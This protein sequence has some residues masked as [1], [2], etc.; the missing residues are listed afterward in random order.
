AGGIHVVAEQDPVGAGQVDVA[1][2]QPPTR[3]ER[4][5][6]GRQAE[7][8]GP[9][10]DL[11]GRQRQRTA[12]GH[13]HVRTTGRAHDGQR[14]VVR[15]ADH[16]GSTGKRDLAGEVVAHVV[17]CD[18]TALRIDRRGTAHPQRARLAHAPAVAGHGQGTGHRTLAQ[19]QRAMLV[20]ESV[21]TS[22]AS[23]VSALA[24]TM[25]AAPPANDTVP[26]KSLPAFART[27]LPLPA[28]NRASPP[29]RNAPD[30]LMSPALA[31][32][33]RS[34][35]TSTREALKLPAS[36]SSAVSA[37]AAPTAP[38]K[39]TAPAACTESRCAPSTVPPKVTS[40]PESRATSAP[41][42]SAPWYSWSPLVLTSFARSMVAARTYRWFASI[43]PR[44]SVLA[45]AISTAPPR[46]STV[47]TKSLPAWLRMMLPLPASNRAS[48][49]TRNAPDWVIA[50]LERTSAAPATTPCPR[51]SAPPLA[52]TRRSAA[53]SPRPSTFASAI[54]TE[55]PRRPTVPTKSLPG[56]VRTML[57][58]P[59]SKRA[60]PPT[61]NAPASTS[62]PD[63]VVFEPTASPKTTTPAVCT[64]S[65]CAPSTAPPK[66]TWPPAS[67]ATSAPSSSA[68]S[69][70]W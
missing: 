66:S 57:R 13:L 37:V 49:P 12:R 48:P 10:I 20:A 51:S 59:A 53:T 52:A 21:A 42:S 33:D 17:E 15:V 3:A 41:S 30:W 18:R 62:S 29:T 2:G 23:S 55:F 34:P 43:V 7:G 70:V 26:M 1:T 69:Y 45:S 68:P 64:E 8:S 58:L 4:A 63:S 19:L 40:P 47:P 54:D 67:R 35:L 25:V 32:T 38:P 44:A 56:F 6:A 28:S 14:E 16:D 50:P 11:P 39:P 36:T 5:A 61:R 22:N 65:R 9:D 24:S 60:S 46:R 27:M 31:T